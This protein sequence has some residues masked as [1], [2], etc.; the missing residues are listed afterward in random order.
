MAMAATM[1]GASAL[2]DSL[3]AAELEL[4]S[5]EAVPGLADAVGEG[6]QAA[7][8]EVAATGAVASAVST[9]AKALEAVGLN[10]ADAASSDIK[11]KQPFWCSFEAISLHWETALEQTPWSSSQLTAQSVEWCLRQGLHGTPT[12]VPSSTCTI[13]AI[14]LAQIGVGMGMMSDMQRVA[15]TWS[16]PAPGAAA[17]EGLP[18]SL[19]A[20]LTPANPAV[21]NRLRASE[22]S[23]MEALFYGHFTPTLA[24]SLEVEV[25]AVYFLQCAGTRSVHRTA[26]HIQCHDVQL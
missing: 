10:L 21:R 2:V 18:T 5:S 3:S 25:S 16:E 9:L 6:F 13:A 22:L 11:V 4:L 24:A 20:K 15:I 17:A 1:A 14:E 19:I 12:L 7:L 23:K 8:T 26:F